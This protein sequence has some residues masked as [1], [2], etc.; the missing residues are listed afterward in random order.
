MY[1][2]YRTTW[3]IEKACPQC[4]T[5]GFAVGTWF[6]IAGL[7][8]PFSNVGLAYNYSKAKSTL[9]LG[10]YATAEKIKAFRVGSVVIMRRPNTKNKKLVSYSYH[11]GLA[12]EKYTTYAVTK[13]A[14]T[15]NSGT[16]NKILPNW[17]REGEFYKIRPYH[18]IW[19]VADWIPECNT[20]QDTIFNSRLSKF[21]QLWH[22]TP[23]Y[24]DL[25]IR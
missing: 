21:I 9:R 20:K 4:P 10:K 15:S 14:N 24:Q 22:E 1:S 12:V 16:L 11:V 8:L 3:N 13:E 17:Y 18:S 19:K 5:C 2:F 23:Q 7:K 25:K 6:K